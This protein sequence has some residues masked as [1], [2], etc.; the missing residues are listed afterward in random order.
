MSPAIKFTLWAMCCIGIGLLLAA[1]DGKSPRAIAFSASVMSLFMA[2][3]FVVWWAWR[4][5]GTRSDDPE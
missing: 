4:R 1:L 3:V 5:R 2:G